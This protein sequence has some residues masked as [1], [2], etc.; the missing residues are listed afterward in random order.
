MDG[1]DPAE[2]ELMKVSD[3]DG[4]ASFQTGQSRDLPSIRQHS[5]GLHSS[6]V[7]L[8]IFH[9]D[10]NRD[11]FQSSPTPTHPQTVF[12]G[13]LTLQLLSTFWNHDPGRELQTE[14][15]GGGHHHHHR[16]LFTPTSLSSSPI[17]KPVPCL[18]LSSLSVDVIRSSETTYFVPRNSW[19]AA[20]VAAIHSLVCRKFQRRWG[21]WWKMEGLVAEWKHDISMHF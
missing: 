13:R 1:R 18:P 4:W 12:G 17:G 6:Q 16:K 10:S 14:W 21:R 11:S 19:N 5:L 7:F 9:L 2:E 20:V 3:A 8:P 15:S